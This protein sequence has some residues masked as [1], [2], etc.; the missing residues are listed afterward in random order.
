MSP[1]NAAIA[2]A[3]LR[4]MRRFNVIDG[5][6]MAPLAESERRDFREISKGSIS[7]AAA[8]RWNAWKLLRASLVF[9]S[10]R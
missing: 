3:Y 9:T 6:A 8:Y 2:V 7:S 4:F 10:H 1:G 5:W